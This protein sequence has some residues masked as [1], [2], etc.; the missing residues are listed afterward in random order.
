M[1]EEKMNEN[2]AVEQKRDKIQTHNANYK[3]KTN[4]AHGTNMC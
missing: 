3:L 1:N 4:N 2:S